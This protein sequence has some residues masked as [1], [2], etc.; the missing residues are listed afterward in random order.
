MVQVRKNSGN[1]KERPMDRTKLPLM[2]HRLI[3][4][5][6]LIRERRGA[7]K[8][9]INAEKSRVPLVCMCADAKSKLQTGYLVEKQLAKAGLWLQTAPWKP[10]L[11]SHFNKEQVANILLYS[12]LSAN[13]L[14]N[15]TS[16]ENILELIVQ[17]CSH[18]G[19]VLI[20][21]AHWMKQKTHRSAQKIQKT[22]TV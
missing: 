16:G 22:T 17:N 11:F 7:E 20:K 10:S 13:P 21:G 2:D 19:V 15:R 14:T 9:Q 8:R 18:P 1:E 4:N 5:H 3:C 12:S 6:L